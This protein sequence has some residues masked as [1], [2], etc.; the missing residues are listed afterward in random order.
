MILHDSMPGGAPTI[1]HLTHPLIEE[2]TE[3][4]N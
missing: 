2:S 3:S 1:I 4:N